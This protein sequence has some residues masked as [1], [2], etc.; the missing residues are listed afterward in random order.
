MDIKLL[1]F[2]RTRLHQHSTRHP[3]IQPSRIHLHR[4]SQRSMRSQMD[5]WW[6]DIGQQSNENYLCLWDATMSGRSNNNSRN[7]T[8]LKNVSSR[9]ILTQN[10]ATVEMLAWWPFYRGLLAS[11]DGPTDRTIKFQNTDSGAMLI[12]IYIGRMFFCC[13]GQSIIRR[14]VLRMVILCSFPS[15]IEIP[16]FTGHT[17]LRTQ[18]MFFFLRFF[19]WS[20]A[21]KVL[22]SY[23]Q[24]Q[25]KHFISGIFSV[26]L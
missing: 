19:T 24:W 25:M 9:Q 23:L 3:R 20:R 6:Y 1:V 11:G 13:F 7:L 12:S 16:K 8:S 21:P 17:S 26:R 2:Q 4:P 10:S 14:F 5:R 18:L 15:M 22:A